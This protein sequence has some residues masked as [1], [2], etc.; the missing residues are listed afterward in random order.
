MNHNWNFFSVYCSALQ[1]RALFQFR[2]RYSS[3]VQWGCLLPQNKRERTRQSKGERILEI[4]V[5]VGLLRR[6]SCM[7]F[8]DIEDR[9]ETYLRIPCFVVLGEHRELWCSRRV[10]FSALQSVSDIHT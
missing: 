8:S 10:E 3:L 7:M 9:V 6:R 4:Q 5:Q 2:C 1:F